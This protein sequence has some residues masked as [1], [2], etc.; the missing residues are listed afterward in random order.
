MNSEKVYVTYMYK[1]GHNLV[2]ESKRNND[3]E[4]KY[5]QYYNPTLCDDCKKG[6]NLV[7]QH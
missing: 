1:C 7:L 2:K 3:K 4:P 5:T 6:G